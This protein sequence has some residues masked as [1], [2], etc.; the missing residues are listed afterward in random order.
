[1]AERTVIYQHQGL[2][3]QAFRELEKYMIH[4]E[5]RSWN[6]QGV[7]KSVRDRQGKR[8][9]EK[10]R[11]SW[12]RNSPGNILSTHQEPVGNNPEI[13]IIPGRTT[14]FMSALVRHR[15]SSMVSDPEF[16]NSAV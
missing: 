13:K 3:D 4:R 6:P 15:I 5:G 11:S 8:S 7:S 16:M 12:A 1:R 10:K 14:E 9:L 2:Y